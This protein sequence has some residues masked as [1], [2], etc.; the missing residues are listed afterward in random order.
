M[1]AKNIISSLYKKGDT[2]DYLSP[3]YRFILMKAE[4]QLESKKS[5]DKNL[6]SRKQ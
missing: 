2:L 4:I 6:I 3:E 5:N 1:L